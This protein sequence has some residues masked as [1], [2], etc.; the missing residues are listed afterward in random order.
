MTQA[1]S[2]KILRVAGVAVAGVACTDLFGGSAIEGRWDFVEM[3]SDEAGTV[4]CSDTGSF[5]ISK[6]GR[7]LSGDFHQVG[8]C[9][10]GS[11]TIDIAHEFP[12]AE[13][14][15]EGGS[16]RFTKVDTLDVLP[17]LNCTYRLAK[18][19]GLEGTVECFRFSGTFRARPASGRSRS[20]TI[21]PDPATLLVGGQIQLVAETRES[22]AQRVFRQA[23]WRS[24]TPAVAKVDASGL[25][26]GLA[27]GTAL[28]RAQ[29]GGRVNDLT[30]A[31]TLTEYESIHAAL[32]YTCALPGIGEALCWGSNQFGQLGNG[33]TVAR[34]TPERVVGQ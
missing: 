26:T 17:E 19:D 22:D 30:V 28:I 6:K 21:A 4:M 10:N 27:P 18:N 12:I 9:S 23:I 33:N 31:V 34:S 3:L 16:V 5:L 7:E 15:E 1:S 20:V 14:T 25:V 11:V 32:G 29:A 24:E 8:T 2:W 13:G